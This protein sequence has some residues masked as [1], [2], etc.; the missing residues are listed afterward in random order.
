MDFV[1]QIGEQEVSFIQF[2]DAVDYIK[3]HLAQWSSFDGVEAQI[4]MVYKR[5]NDTPTIGINSTESIEVSD[6]FGGLPES[7]TQRQKETYLKVLKI[8]KDEGIEK[9]RAYIRNQSKR[10]H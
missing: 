4:I 2:N 10:K 8:V 7:W 9:A 6:V 3:Q 5:P 1:V